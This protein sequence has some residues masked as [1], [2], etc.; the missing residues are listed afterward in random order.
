LL[1][2][3]CHYGS[4]LDASRVQAISSVT[5]SSAAVCRSRC[6]TL[7]SF[8]STMTAWMIPCFH[9]DDNRL[10]LWNCKPA[11]IKCFSLGELPWSWCLFTST[12]IQT[13]TLSKVRS[14]GGRENWLLSHPLTSLHEHCGTYAITNTNMHRDRDTHIH[15]THM[16]IYTHT[17]IDIYKYYTHTHTHT[18]THNFLFQRPQFIHN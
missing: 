1:G 3:V 17:N 9:H 6:E 13:K 2:E 7:S 10:S 14:P 18:H 4:S 5:D 12:E 15:T 11:P 16:H 8:S